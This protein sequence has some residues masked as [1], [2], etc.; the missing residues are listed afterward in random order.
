VVVVSTI[1]AIN[2]NPE[3]AT[4]TGIRAVMRGL[5]RAGA[6][7]VERHYRRVRPTDVDGA[8]AYDAV[9]LGPQGVPFDAYPDLDHMLTVIRS[10][11]LP[12]LAVCGGFQALVLAWGGSLAPVH[13]GTATGVYRSLHKEVGLRTITW[14]EPRDPLV[15]GLP[16]QQRYVVSH[17]E[18]VSSLPT[19]FRLI[20]SG[21]PCRVQAIRLAEQP[22]WGVQFHPEKGGDGAALL[23][24]FIA[25][26][27]PV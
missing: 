19:C 14:E 9:V 22:V 24:R 21:D 25:T 17:F 3:A 1:L 20:G 5:R 2:L 27:S 4:R 26:I 16:T 11:G 18:G 23:A 15:A 10:I 6:R 13:G 7:V 12:T 8:S